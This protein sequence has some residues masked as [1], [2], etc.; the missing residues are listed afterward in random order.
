MMLKNRRQRVQVNDSYSDWGSATSGVPQG[1]VL[2]PLLFLIYI[3]DIVDVVKHSNIKLYADDSKIYHSFER[4][5]EFSDGLQDDLESIAAWA[6]SWQLSVNASKCFVLPVGN[7]LVSQNPSRYSLNDVALPTVKVEKD[8]GVFMSG[9]LRFSEHCS[10]IASS[11]SQVAGIIFRAFASKDVCFMVKMFITYIRPILEYNS[12]VWSPSLLGDIDVVESIQRSYTRRIKNLATI[13]YTDRL[14]V[15]K[16]DPLE[17]RRLKRDMVLVYKIRHGLV[18]LAFEDFFVFAPVVGTRG[19][20]DK[21]YPQKA[22]T[23]R[24]LASF[25]NRVAGPWNSLPE[26]LIIATSISQFKIGLDSLHDHLKVFL[27]GRAIRSL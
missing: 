2:G 3:N 18:K 10:K 6:A 25:A 5:A 12:E 7:R 22:K 26:P 4:E 15:C 11:A 21:L 1:S 27:R 20:R 16:L 23:N 14:N 19:H 8:L 24:A 13:S 17:L 9:D